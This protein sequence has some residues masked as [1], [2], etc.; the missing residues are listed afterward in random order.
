MRKDLTDVTII[1]DRSGSMEA[2]AAEANNGIAAFVKKQQESKDGEVLISLVEFDH[3]YNTVY[4][5]LPASVA[6][7]Y[8][9]EPRGMTALLDAVGRTIFDTGKRLSEMP[10]S[11]R[12]GLVILVVVTDGC[13][14]ASKEFS[15]TKVKA[16]IQEQETKYG[17]TFVYLGADVRGF[18]E[19]RS[20][21]YAAD[22][23]AVY[24]PANYV[25]TMQV[26]SEKVNSARKSRAGGQCLSAAREAMCFSEDDRSALAGTVK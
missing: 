25:Q 26:V 17:W 15:A 3:D 23:S 6:P 2:I 13:E 14:N 7:E 10:E 16:M 21:G 12:P 8:K 11:E 4:S 22:T 5:G 1:V 24:Q 20:F 9:I 19:A 18:Q